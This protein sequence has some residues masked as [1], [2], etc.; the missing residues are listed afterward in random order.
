MLEAKDTKLDYLAV[1]GRW[2]KFAVKVEEF[3]MAG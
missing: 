1:K 3:G 2:H